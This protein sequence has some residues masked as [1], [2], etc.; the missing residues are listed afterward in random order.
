MSLLTHHHNHSTLIS[1]IDLV[2][3]CEGSQEIVM[4]LAATRCQS[5]TTFNRE[6]LSKIFV[7][8]KTVVFREKKLMSGEESITVGRLQMCYIVVIIK[9]HTYTQP[10]CHYYILHTRRL[11]AV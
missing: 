7:R 3:L 11:N 10:D 6:A 2:P 4:S 5:S 8:D 1:Q 9:H